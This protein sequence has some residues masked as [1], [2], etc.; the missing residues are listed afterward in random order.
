[1]LYKTL[2]FMSWCA[3][4]TPYCVLMAIGRILGN[5]YY[6][7]VKK[8]RKRAVEQ[9]MVSLEIPEAEAKELIR[10][11]FVNLARNMLEILYMPNLNQQN[12]HEYID[13]EHFERVKAAHEEG[14]GIVVITGHIGTWEWMSAAMALKGI[15]TTAIAKPQPNLDYTR[16][17]D[18]LRAMVHVE[19]FSRGTSELLAAGRALKKGKILG[20]LMDQDAG[21]GGAFME[22]LGRTASTP[23]GAAVFARKFGSPVVP[24]FILRQKSGKHKIVIGEIMRY[25]D[26]GDTDKDL[27]DFTEKMT[28]L[29]DRMI[30]ENP[31]Q[32]IWFQKRWN[33]AP[34]HQ[35]KNKHHTVSSKEKRG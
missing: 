8:Q 30:R 1:M 12:L 26:T 19:V 18:D 32:W 6:L 17:L 20:F 27:F 16:A 9:M 7:F 21:P 4:H 23:M 2:M 5:L 33:T 14:R 22:F 25:E 29:I 35:K 10:E 31:T 11:S 3:R 15:P 13:I 28:K 34:E 24:M